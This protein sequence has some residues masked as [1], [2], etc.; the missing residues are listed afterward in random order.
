[1]IKRSFNEQI[2]GYDNSF[3][4]KVLYISA[5]GLAL[6]LTFMDVSKLAECL[7]LLKCGWMLLVAAICLNLYSQLFA[8]GKA[9]KIRDLLNND[10]PDIKKIKSLIIDGNKLISTMNWLTFAALILGISSIVAFVIINTK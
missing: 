7:Y 6:S 2:K 3:E 4:Q 9:C 1:M 5:G 10:H 8:K